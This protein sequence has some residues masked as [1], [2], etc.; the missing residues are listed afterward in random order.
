MYE[1]LFAE[2]IL[3][4]PKIHSLH[5]FHGVVMPNVGQSGSTLYV[6]SLLLLTVACALPQPNLL[7][8]TH[9]GYGWN[10]A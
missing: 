9:E 5:S 2:K 8:L 7:D 6:P 10:C 1:Q 3:G 4:G